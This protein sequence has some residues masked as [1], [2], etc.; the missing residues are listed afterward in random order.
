MICFPS[1]SWSQDVPIQL[2]CAI[3]LFQV[4]ADGQCVVEI[5][6]QTGPG[7]MDSKEEAETQA[8]MSVK[9]NCGSS[10]I[11]VDCKRD[12][13]QFGGV[14]KQVQIAGSKN[15]WIYMCLVNLGVALIIIIVF[16]AFSIIKKKPDDEDSYYDS[17]SSVLEPLYPF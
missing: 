13:W 14:K 4:K 10:H 16:L 9:P 8:I 11:K 5:P 1:I 6:Y 7:G 3:S 2:T 17:S 12:V 15:L